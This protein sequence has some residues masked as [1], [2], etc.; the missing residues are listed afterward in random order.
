MTTPFQLCQHCTYLT[1]L[2]NDEKYSLF[3]PPPKGFFKCR[4]LTAVLDTT[5]R[6]LV[7]EW[8]H[9]FLENLKFCYIVL[10]IFFSH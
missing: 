3:L 6:N 5:L 8:K 7:L 10:L 2:L 4:W 9:I 1:N